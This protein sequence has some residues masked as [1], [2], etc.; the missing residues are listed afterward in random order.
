MQNPVRG[1]LHG[2]AAIAGVAGL[3]VMVKRAGDGVRLAG[4]LVFGLA[5]VAMFTVSALYHSIAWTGAWK[6]RMQRLDHSMIFIMVAATFTPLCLAT[7]SGA[8]LLVVLTA[9]W[10]TAAA[11]VVIKVSSR[12]VR[13]GLSLGLQ[14]GLGWAS[15]GLLPVF[16]QRLGSGA[17]ALIL[18][19]G[20]AYT[21]G[22]VI[23]A[24]KRPRLSPRVFS[25]HELFHLLVVVGCALHFAAIA[26]FAI[27]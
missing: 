15:L 20:L 17:V 4:A 3:V 9:V 21:S 6:R 5:L 19:G 13:T 1:L 22:T 18:L 27:T 26:G 14:L 2:G 11:G 10:S 12:R 23:F 7:L 16:W 8:T 24:I 25:Y